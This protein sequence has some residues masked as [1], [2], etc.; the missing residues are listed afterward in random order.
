MRALSL[1]T[2][3]QIDIIT[4]GDKGEIKQAG[5][6]DLLT[7]VVKAHTTN[8]AFAIASEAIQVHGGLGYVEETGV[9]QYLRDV[10]VAMIYEG[11]NGIQALDLSL[12]KLPIDEGRVM[13]EL[14]DE[15][16]KTAATLNDLN[17][18]RLLPL[19]YA[20]AK[21]IKH[22]RDASRHMLVQV[23]VTQNNSKGK[24]PATASAV[25]FLALFGLTLQGWLLAREALHAAELEKR[26]DNSGYATDFLTRK[27][28]LARFF[29]L[30]C[31]LDT[32]ALHDR[33]LLGEDN[34]IDPGPGM[35]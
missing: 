4:A 29:V 20:L 25:P 19:G 33:V 32:T 16:T 9:A 5:L 14:I 11:T 24:A 22:L 15:M 30:D 34:L 13:S 1:F 3:R 10:R 23:Q 27:I 2:N 12:R 31:L 18:Y 26:E 28:A 8:T 21:S 6:L 7:S 17:D 35:A